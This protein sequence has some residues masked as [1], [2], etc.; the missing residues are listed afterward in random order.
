MKS[1]NKRQLWD[2]EEDIKLKELVLKSNN[3]SWKEI[4]ENFS[5]RSSKQCR[6]R[7]VNY[8]NPNLEDKDWTLDEDNTLVQLHSMFGNKWSKIALIMKGKSENSIKN[9]WYGSI[10][11]R[12][13][14]LDGNLKLLNPTSRGRPSKNNLNYNSVPLFNNKFQINNQNS[15]P[16]NQISNNNN[17]KTISKQLM[18]PNFPNNNKI[19][20]MSVEELMRKNNF[21]I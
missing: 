21:L 20:F 16:L 6:D 18:K 8:L 1:E 11:K 12:I 15:V 7:W 17:L 13:T 9:R 5:D 4:S 14:I 3:I 2:I 19:Q 10:S